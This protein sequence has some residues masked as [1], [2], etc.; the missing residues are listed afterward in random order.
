MRKI[1]WLLSLL[2]V[3]A[4]SALAQFAIGPGITGAWYDPLQSGHGLF[5]EVLPDNRFYASWFAFDPAGA[6]QAWFTGVGTYE[7]NTASITAVSNHRR[8]LDSPDPNKSRNAL[9]TLTFLS[10]TATMASGFQLGVGLRHGEHEPH[11]ADAAGRTDLSV[12]RVARGRPRATICVRSLRPRPCVCA[13]WSLCVRLARH[14]RPEPLDGV[15]RLQP[16]HCA[17]RGRSCRPTPLRRR[18]STRESVAQSRKRPTAVSTGELVVNAAW[19]S[20]ELMIDPSS[21]S[22][23]YAGHGGLQEY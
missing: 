4:K 15:G 11:A 21:P 23:L 6:Q 2:L 22:T 16:R 17:R 14:R 10:P 1:I 3:G 12:K 18:R 5:I 9:G 19:G 8:T 13:V 7:G 20:I